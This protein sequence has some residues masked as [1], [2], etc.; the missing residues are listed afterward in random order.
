MNPEDQNYGAGAEA[1]HQAND[2]QNQMSIEEEAAKPP[3]PEVDNS[4]IAGIEADEDMKSLSD[5]IHEGATQPDP[6]PTDFASEPAK[7]EAEKKPGS[8]KPLIIGIVAVV[9]LAAA[10]FGIWALLSAGGEDKGGAKPDPNRMAFFVEGENGNSSYAIYNDKGEKLTDFNYEMLSDFNSAGYA[11]VKK[12]GTE[13]PGIMTN[14][15]KYS[16]AP[17]K[18]TSIEAFGAYFAV[19]GEEGGEILIDGSGKKLLDIESRMATIGLYS[20]YD[21]SSSVVY[22]KEGTKIGESDSKKPLNDITVSDDNVCMTY[23][24]KVRCYNTKTGDKYAEFDS[25][26]P[27]TL[28]LTGAG[29]VSKNHQCMRLAS[30]DKSNDKLYLYY[31]G[32]LYSVEGYKTGALG[33]TERSGH[34]NCFFTDHNVI[35]GKDGKAVKM[36]DGAKSATIVVQDSDHYIYY[37]GLGTGSYSLYIH[38]NGE[39]RVI[40][41]DL[42]YVPSID[43]GATH[44]TAYYQ[45][46]DNGFVIEYYANDIK[47]LYTKKAGIAD[48]NFSSPLDENGNFIA[49]RQI[50]NK[51]KDEAIYNVPYSVSTASIIYEDGYYFV[52]GY[53][54][55]ADDLNLGLV[56]KDGKEI[57]APGKYDSFKKFGKYLV[58]KKG[59]A[60]SLLNIDSKVLLENYDGIKV[61]DSHIEAL[62]DGKTEYYLLDMTKVK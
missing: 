12:V 3:V 2:V 40:A 1:A 23:D 54:L 29:T 14:I 45:H 18:Y 56:D 55:D 19:K 5:V 20:I 11:A 7:P 42:A 38:A 47:P 33:V 26:E 22:D 49:Y 62:K 8:K 41:K 35:F 57:L 43:G 37:T 32:S 46:P 16:I 52:K 61:T 31:Y 53:V 27:L 28:Y 60:Y 9:V 58:A 34:G 51:D 4:I 30:T 50:Y 24:K 39:E 36:P 15:G 21:G 13:T 10:G 25:D 44:F 6:T 59:E 48:A 17:G